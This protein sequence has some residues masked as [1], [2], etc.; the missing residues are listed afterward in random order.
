V[1]EVETWGCL[2]RPILPIASTELFQDLETDG[3]LKSAPDSPCCEPE[4][5]VRKIVLLV[6]K[7]SD[8]LA[9]YIN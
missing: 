3:L 8:H 1:A 9:R 6:S 7:M 4:I 5:A 2:Q